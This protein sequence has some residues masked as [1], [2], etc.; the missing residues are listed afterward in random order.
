MNRYFY[1]TFVLA[2]AL[3]MLTSGFQ[4]SQAIA[5]T[6]RTDVQAPRTNVQTPRTD[7]QKTSGSAQKISGDDQFFKDI[8]RE[9]YETYRLGPGDEIAIRVT[10]HSDY[11]LE[12]AKVSPT[13]SV[14]HPLLGDIEVAGMTVPKLIKG[15][16]RDLGEY[17]IDP[18]VSAALLEANSAK[19]GVIGDVMRPGIL[20]MNKPMTV[21][22]AVTSSG[23]FT[24]T[25]SKSGVI[26]L[27]STNDGRAQTLKVNVKRILEGKAGEEE[28]IALH[29]GDTVIVNGNTRKKLSNI[30]SLAGF[31]S[32]LSFISAGG[33][34]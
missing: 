6:S 32:F 16:T 33:G 4:L 26:V 5:Q 21:L 22:E 31:A 14:Y 1:V 17:L 24:D 13:G 28:N 8:Y 2:S 10:G 7:A 18:K 15:L 34:R 27:R 29:A 12:R 23:G 20:V 19:I 9:F 25:G 3:S 30:L 11:T